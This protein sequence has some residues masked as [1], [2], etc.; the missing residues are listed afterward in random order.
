MGCAS[1]TCTKTNAVSHPTKVRRCCN[2]TKHPGGAAPKVAAMAPSVPMR[3]GV[4]AAT[5]ADLDPA[6]VVLRSPTASIP[7]IGTVNFVAAEAHVISDSYAAALAVV[8]AQVRQDAPSPTAST[9][10]GVSCVGS[11]FSHCTNSSEA[12]SIPLIAETSHISTLPM[13][14]ASS[15]EQSSC[16]LNDQAGRSDEHTAGMAMSCSAS[17]GST[18]CS[19]TETGAELA[20][21]SVAALVVESPIA[22]QPNLDSGMGPVPSE[23]V[24]IDCS[25]TSRRAPQHAK[26]SDEEA[27]F[28]HTDEQPSIANGLAQEAGLLQMGDAGET[29]R[30]PLRGDGELTPQDEE[31]HML[32]TPVLLGTAAPSELNFVAGTASGQ[33][34]LLHSRNA[35]TCCRP[36]IMKLLRGGQQRRSASYQ[37]LHNFTKVLYSVHFR[38]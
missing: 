37:F 21:A 29:E 32:Q 33:T 5:Q 4:A 8:A 15:T 36:P 22:S 14:F 38:R 6:S 26:M 19:A 23:T 16:A 30:G 35:E 10:S 9:A 1:S 20:S 28:L 27:V 13:S 12:S 11:Q 7:S 18:E 31:A 3:S 2:R 34:I 25:A 24:D 17:D